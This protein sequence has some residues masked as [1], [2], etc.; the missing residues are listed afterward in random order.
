MS[1]IGKPAKN[2]TANDIDNLLL[3]RVSEGKEIEYK[4]QHPGSDNKA[5]LSHI[6][7]IS[8]FA[9]TDGGYL[10]YRIDAKDAIPTSISGIGN[11]NI[12]DELLRLDEM[13]RDGLRP[14]V[15]GIEYQPV[16]LAAGN[17]VLVIYVPRS[18][19]S[20]HQIIAQ[21]ECRFYGRA[22][23]GKYM[24]DVDDLR[25]SFLRTDAAGA[26]IRRFRNDRALQIQSRQE[27]V[28]LAA[29]SSVVLHAYPL[30]ALR[31]GSQIDLKK[32][33]TTPRWLAMLGGGS[34]RC[35][36]DGLISRDDMVARCS[37][38]CQ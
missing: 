36:I 9:N 11:V 28:P 37:T 35:N 19:N 6:K 5:R 33:Q 18:L 38:F 21:K 23:N 26:T 25:A 3:N 30:S 1:V 4:R 10:I 14:R 22:S 27:G 7:A 20:P 12:D 31:V 16:T 17:S 15:N 8:S 32:V 29:G 13:A 34:L 2:V 24:L